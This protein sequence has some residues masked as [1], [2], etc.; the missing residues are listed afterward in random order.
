V[1]FS[2]VNPKKL[3]F[4]GALGWVVGTWL[5]YV[6]IKAGLAAAFS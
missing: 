4:S 1:G 5:L 3:K 6:L 2:S